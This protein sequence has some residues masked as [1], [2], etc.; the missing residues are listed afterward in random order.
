MRRMPISGRAWGLRLT[1]GYEIFCCFYAFS[2]PANDAIQPIKLCPIPCH[3]RT[4]F[5]IT[6]KQ[7]SCCIADEAGYFFSHFRMVF[8]EGV[9]HGL[10]AFHGSPGGCTGQDTI[11]RVF[12]RGNGFIDFSL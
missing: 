8:Q 6:T 2:A 7:L 5:F 4:S 9:K 3:S 12:Y 11:Q 10:Q 1:S